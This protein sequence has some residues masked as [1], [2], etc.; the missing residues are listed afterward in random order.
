MHCEGDSP[1]ADSGLTLLVSSSNAL[2]IVVG[3]SGWSLDRLTES[4]WGSRE[5]NRDGIAAGVVVW[6]VWC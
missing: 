6:W 2:S 1:F 4:E 5:R 3:L